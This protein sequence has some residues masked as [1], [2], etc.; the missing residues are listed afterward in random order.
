MIDRPFTTRQ[1]AHALG[2][3]PAVLKN[4]RKAGIA[5]AALKMP[6]RGGSYLWEAD[7]IRR[8][9]ALGQGNK[10][11]YRARRLKRDARYPMDGLI[12]VRP[13][14]SKRA[15]RSSGL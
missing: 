15:S 14:P 9:L 10:R 12:I 2:I 11:I 8:L 6:G 7:E 13:V 5:H 1:A 3:D 4:M